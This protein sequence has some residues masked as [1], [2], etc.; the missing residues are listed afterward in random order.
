MVVRFPRQ[1][2]EHDHAFERARSEDRVAAG[3]RK[4][5]RCCVCDLEGVAKIAAFTLGLHG[6]ALL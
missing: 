5:R 6:S 2:V 4:V 3:G 1:F